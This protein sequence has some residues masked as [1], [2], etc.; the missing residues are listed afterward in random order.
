MN[1][2]KDHEDFWEEGQ[3]AV[4]AANRLRV[5]Y[6]FED[7]VCFTD[8]F[9][10]T[11]KIINEQD[12]AWEDYI[13]FLD[14]PVDPDNDVDGRWDDSLYRMAAALVTIHTLRLEIAFDKEDWFQ[15]IEMLR[16]YSENL[17]CIY[18]LLTYPF[19]NEELRKWTRERHKWL[20]L[21]LAIFD[22]TGGGNNGLR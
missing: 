11:I 21:E 5:L 14:L 22:H 4:E 19:S 10:D 17:L 13:E 18:Y 9:R 15:T 20:P 2:E 6:L 3:L 12:F 8:V 16:A 7:E 1:T